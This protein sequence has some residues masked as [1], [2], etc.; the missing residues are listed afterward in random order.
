MHVIIT[1]YVKINFK[2]KIF[3]L[4]RPHTGKNPVGAGF[5]MHGFL[6]N[7][8]SVDKIAIIR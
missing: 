2:Q 8:K 3:S 1:R 6:Q 5:S 4:T 7:I